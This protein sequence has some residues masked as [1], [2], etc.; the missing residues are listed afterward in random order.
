MAFGRRSITKST[1]ALLPPVV[2]E[3]SDRE[4]SACD[5]DRRYGFDDLRLDTAV[6]FRFGLFRNPVID[7]NLLRYRLGCGEVVGVVGL[8]TDLD[9]H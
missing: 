8:N 6:R 7:P 4:N 1:P 3:L 2:D 9:G 5:Q